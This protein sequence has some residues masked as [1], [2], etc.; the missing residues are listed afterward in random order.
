MIVTV[1]LW[2][3]SKLAADGIVNRKKRFRVPPC[4]TG[5]SSKYE[6]GSGEINVVQFEPSFENSHFTLFNP[7]VEPSVHASIPLMKF[8]L[9]M[10]KAAGPLFTVITRPSF[11]PLAVV[12]L[13]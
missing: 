5:V 3:V 2:L 10:F 4:T 7:L 12:S 8:V 11:A 9:F 1:E 13:V 6:D